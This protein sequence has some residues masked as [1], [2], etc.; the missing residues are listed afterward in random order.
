MAPNQGERSNALEAVTTTLQQELAAH[1]AAIEKNF[2]TLISNIKADFAATRAMIDAN[3]A[4]LI[5]LLMSLHQG[6][7]LPPASPMPVTMSSLSTPADPASV[8]LP[9]SPTP[10]SGCDAAAGKVPLPIVP[11][12]AGGPLFADL[13][14]PRDEEE[15]GADVACRVHLAK[16]ARGSLEGRTPG[17]GDQEYQHRAAMRLVW[18][19]VCRE[20][21]A[22]TNVEA[23]PVRRL[24]PRKPGGIDLLKVDPEDPKDHPS[25]PDFR[26]WSA[27]IRA[28][29]RASSRYR[30]D[31]SASGSA[32]NHFVV[33]FIDI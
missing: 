5:A 12:D 22:A 32:A 15:G 11:P 20:H 24:R 21:A 19:S 23:S 33:D 7:S 31:G 30:D 10:A 14:A 13:V 27:P 17:E 16:E 18:D 4:A 1:R 25:S 29:P 9:P 28:T 6:T 26:S 2:A 8:E 3:H